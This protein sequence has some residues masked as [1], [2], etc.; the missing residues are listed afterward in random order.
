MTLAKFEQVVLA[1]KM[2]STIPDD[3]DPTVHPDLEVEQLDSV[4][5]C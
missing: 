1:T 5:G 4:I 3:S 2:G